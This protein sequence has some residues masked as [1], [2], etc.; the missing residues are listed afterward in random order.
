MS[1]HEKELFIKTRDFVEAT[2]DV[3]QSATGRHKVVHG[4]A[5]LTELREK[6]D[7]IV[8]DDMGFDTEKLDEV[9][10]V[11]N[12][13][14]RLYYQETKPDAGLIII[15][16]ERK[17]SGYF[18]HAVAAAA[19]QRAGWVA[20]RNYLWQWTEGDFH[21]ASYCYTNIYVFRKGTMAT[22]QEAEYRYKDIIRVPRPATAENKIS[23]VMEVPITVIENYIKL[24]KLPD[25]ALLFDPF[26]GTGTLMKAADNLGYRS[27]SVELHRGRFDTLATK[28]IP[29]LEKEIGWKNV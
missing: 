15:P 2:W 26:A 14:G 19:M 18:K 3:V 24:F 29:Q 9:E 16:R 5:F 6:A 1:D 17:G 28:V 23:A 20:F 25:N 13:L 7:L 27:T 22:R 12:R 4:D 11:F 21:R 10:D 8:T